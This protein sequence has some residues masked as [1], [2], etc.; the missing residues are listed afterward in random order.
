MPAATRITICPIEAT[1][2]YGELTRFEVDTATTSLREVVERIHADPM[3]HCKTA[4]VGTQLLTYEDDVTGD[5]IDMFNPSIALEPLAAIVQHLLPRAAA[6]GLSEFAEG[7]ELW[8]VV[9]G[10]AT[11]SD[12][13]AHMG[14]ALLRAQFDAMARQKESAAFRAMLEAIALVSVLS[15]PAAAASALEAA[16][17][18]SKMDVAKCLVGL[19]PNA[20]VTTSLHTAA[21]KGHT[22]SVRALVTQLG[23]DVAATDENGQTPLHHAATNGHVSAAKVLARELAA[24]ASASDANHRTPLHLAAGNGHVD[25]LR[26]LT[27][28]LRAEIGATD[29]KGRTALHC[30]ASNGHSAAARVLVRELGAA[31]GTLDAHRETPLH[32]AASHGHTDTALALASELGADVSARNAGGATPLHNAAE[33]GHAAA[34]WMFA[35]ALGADPTAKAKN[36]QTPLHAAAENGHSDVVNVLVRQLGAD[37]SARDSLERT[38]LHLGRV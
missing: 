27:N 24:N 19:I 12:A 11:D 4:R 26:L 29:V 18:G 7:Q 32:T 1:N 6:D 10:C 9:D 28:E 16:C 23:A 14:G 5:P 31:V 35:K 2:N 8:L 22:N 25:T 21:S 30:A 20:T 13:I 36:G 38:P 37:A 34:V 33:R 17:E 3:L 15:A